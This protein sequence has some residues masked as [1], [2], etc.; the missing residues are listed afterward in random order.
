VRALP[1]AV[2]TAT[3]PAAIA[4]P[5]SAAWTEQRLPLAGASGYSKQAPAANARRDVAV[6][7]G[8]RPQRF[9]AVR[10]AGRARFGRRIASRRG[11]RR[12]P[13]RPRGTGRAS[14]RIEP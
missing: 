14:R 8:A 3:A 5:A 2:L 4:V 10:R 7:W 9:L 11:R 1:L 13:E 6:V 12:R